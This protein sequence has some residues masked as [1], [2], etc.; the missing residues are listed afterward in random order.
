MVS[1]CPKS[2][3]SPTTFLWHLIDAAAADVAP[4]MLASKIRERVAAQHS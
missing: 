3:F 4:V 1:F 2:P